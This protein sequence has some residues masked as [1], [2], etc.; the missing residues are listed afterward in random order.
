MT[1]RKRDYLALAEK[2]RNRTCSSLL[3]ASW[4]PDREIVG[5]NQVTQMACWGP[6][7][8]RLA[9]YRLISM[10]TSTE[11]VILSGREIHGI[12]KRPAVFES[13]VGAPNRPQ[14]PQSRK[15]MR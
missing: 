13:I 1:T 14:E 3:H 7:A 10:E 11:S 15:R 12:A 5:R 8:R 6:R 2:R 9:L 4:Q